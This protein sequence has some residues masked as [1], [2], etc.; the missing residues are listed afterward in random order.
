MF[1][2]RDK[3]RGG[4][5]LHEPPQV[6][7]QE[8]Q[9]CPRLSRVRAFRPYVVGVVDSLRCPELSFHLVPLGLV[10]RDLSLRFLR[11]HRQGDSPKR[12]T[13]SP[14][15][16]EPEDLAVPLVHVYLVSVNLLREMSSGALHVVEE[17]GTEVLGFVV[18]VPAQVVDERVSAAYGDAD[19]RAE[20]DPRG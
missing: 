6:L 14:D 11:L 18:R 4:E 19:L 5:G 17:V 7:C 16:Q 9:R 12:L 13:G 1:S 2:D 10:L 3:K 20:L 15:S 8:A